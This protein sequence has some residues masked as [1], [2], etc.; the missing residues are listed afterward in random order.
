MKEAELSANEKIKIMELE[1]LEKS[2]TRAR[3]HKLYCD[4]ELEKIQSKRAKESFEQQ[5]HV[6][7]MTHTNSLMLA[8]IGSNRSEGEI[9]QMMSWIKPPSGGF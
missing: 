2:Q 8:L 1:S 6:S 3:K 4:L 7:Q 9:E 5:C